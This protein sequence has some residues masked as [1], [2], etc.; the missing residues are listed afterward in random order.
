LIEATELSDKLAAKAD[1]KPGGPALLWK[2]TDPEGRVFY[3]EERLTSIKSPYNGKTF[4]AKPKRFTPAQVGQEMREEG[5]EAKKAPKTPKGPK[6][7]ADWA[8]TSGFDSNM[9]QFDRDLQK[10]Y[11]DLTGVDVSL[12]VLGMTLEKVQ[13]NDVTP[14]EALQDLNDFV[15]KIRRAR[16]T[17]NVSIRDQFKNLERIVKSGTAASKMT[18][19][20]L[21]SRSESKFDRLSEDGTKLALAISRDID[22]YQHIMEQIQRLP[23]MPSRAVAT[24]KEAASAADKDINRWKGLMSSYF[25]IIATHMKKEEGKEPDWSKMNNNHIMVAKKDPWAAKTAEDWVSDGSPEENWS[26]GIHTDKWESLQAKHEKLTV[27]ISQ[28]IQEYTNLM[29][30]VQDYKNAPPKVKEFA[31]KCE[32]MGRK[33]MKTWK[34]TF[35]DFTV[36]EHL[37]EES[38]KE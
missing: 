25:P 24:A 4:V 38:H 1:P 18:F 16:W 32:D 14:K 21:D 27:E 37:F 22:T 19:T 29:E 12:S 31:R 23:G 17:W 26:E 28:D 7:A 5:Q 35:D 6:T 10:I 8:V 33:E 3:L 15:S 36:L 9:R 20:A 2:Y 13:D 34:D 11:S 30:D